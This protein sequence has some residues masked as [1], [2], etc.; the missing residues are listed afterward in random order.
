MNTSHLWY[1]DKNKTERPFCLHDD[2]KTDKLT[3]TEQYPQNTLKL[4][5]LSSYLFAELKWVTS[6]ISRDD[7]P[8]TKATQSIMIITY[9]HFG[10][11][12]ALPLGLYGAVY[13][14]LDK[15]FLFTSLH[16]AIL[17]ILY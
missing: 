3:K 10:C 17:K 9:S 2:D 12:H 16:R 7:K 5:V 4:Y 14:D 6:I 15:Y 8:V 13:Y 11:L 1:R